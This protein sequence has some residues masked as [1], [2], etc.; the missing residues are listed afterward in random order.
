[1]SLIHTFA[2]N[3]RKYRLEHNLS[4]EHLAELAGLHRT[5]ISSV[6]RERRNI[7]I[8]NIQRISDALKIEPYR[9]FVKDSDEHR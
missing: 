7:S 5:Y 9:L 3:V 8:E 1:M 6:E 2:V 4:Q